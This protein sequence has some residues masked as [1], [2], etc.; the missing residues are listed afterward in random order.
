MSDRTPHRKPPASRPPRHSIAST[1]M[2]I[3]ACARCWPADLDEYLHLYLVNRGALLTPFHDMAVMSP[4]TSDADTHARTEVFA[5][6]A[7]ELLA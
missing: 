5:A 6:A 1:L 4:A 2:V 3:R 7:G